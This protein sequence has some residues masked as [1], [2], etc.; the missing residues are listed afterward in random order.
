MALN[1]NEIRETLQINRS[2]MT[3]NRMLTNELIIDDFMVGL[4]YNKKRDTSVKRCYNGE[5]D[6]EVSS[7]TGFRIAVKVFA[8]GET[9]IQEELDKAMAYAGEKRFSI[10][11]VT[12][13]EALTVCRYIKDKGVYA[14]VCDINFEDELD[15]IGESVLSAISK[16][17]FD[18]QLIDKYVKQPTMTDDEM[19]ELIIS[20]KE[21]IASVV[22]A[23]S[24]SNNEDG[25]KQCLKVLDTILNRKDSVVESNINNRASSEEIAKAKQETEMLRAELNAAR[26]ELIEAKEKIT[27]IQESGGAMIDAD[28]KSIEEMKAEIDRLTA[29]VLADDTEKDIQIQELE[30]EVDRLKKK[31][32][33]SSQFT[34]GDTKVDNEIASYRDQIN[35]LTIKLSNE[36]ETVKQ[37]K[38]DLKKANDE[39]NNMTGV[40]RK[41][42]H[43]LLM[44]IEDNPDLDRHYVGVVNT[45]LLQYDEIHTFV[46]RSLQMLYELKRLEASQ[47]IFN[48]DIFKLIQPAIRNDLIMNNKAYDVSFEDRHE[49]D[50]LN[51]LRILFSHFNDVIFECKKIG[52]LRVDPFAAYEEAEYT[53]VN[54]ESDS[55]FTEGYIE[56]EVA[57]EYSEDNYT[58]DTNEYTADNTDYSVDEDSVDE[59]SVG[60]NSVGEEVIDFS[61]NNT[62][63]SLEKSEE[64][65][66]ESEEDLFA[67][68]KDS[69]FDELAIEDDT[70]DS[71]E[72][73][74]ELAIEDDTQEFR[75]FEDGFT[76]NDESQDTW[77]TDGSL[78]DFG[79]DDNFDPTSMEPQLIVAQ[80]LQIDN[81]I[82]MEDV[83]LELQNVKYIGTN[84]I[85]FNIN[86]DADE[87]SNEQLLC[88]CVDAVMAIEAYNGNS[89]IVNLLKQTDFSQINNFLQLYTDEFRGYPRINGTK[90]VVTNIDTIQQV[91]AV[92]YDICNY[93][94]ID[95]SELFIY[96]TATTD[97]DYII[98]NYGYEEDAVQ[99]R[100]YSSHDTYS[101]AKS[102]AIIQGDLFSNIVV[103]KGSLK[104]HKEIIVEAVAVKTKYLAK[105][106]NTDED[107]KEVVEQ[108]LTES[109]RFGRVDFN[110]IGNVIGETHKILS[111]N[112]YDIGNNYVELNV[113]GNYYYLAKVEKWQVLHSLIKLHTA[114]FNDTAIA[115]KTV[116]STDAI[117][118]Y[119]T[120]FETSEP[121]LSLA[122]KSF[123][124]YVALKVKR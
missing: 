92:L 71:E 64:T 5:V 45:E 110:A 114:I 26:E 6:W 48:G 68:G 60:E 79:E 19:T 105:V 107:Y 15:E 38:E 47:Y 34:T 42:A 2:D 23:K 11:I 124:D 32:I 7:P 22:I 106:L 77:E 10:F 8:I 75:G 109:A 55:E 12:N 95:M 25:K 122:V 119:G 104:A 70:D 39:I 46:G 40:E 90:Y 117:N 112:T 72:F 69:N 74:D 30:A 100:D 41:K 67:G 81:L 97:S 76:D 24:S 51:K 3:N 59:D 20:C 116:I 37:L 17:T 108:M 83:N 50:V 28:G 98:E 123:S 29:A 80:L 16:D 33:S 121:S 111:D 31:L 14:E 66:S 94:N 120:E 61:S 43:E 4:G 82:W 84:S 49:D 96:M 102:V 57:E 44:V 87:V 36:Q 56:D 18:L 63:I 113:A 99:L 103:T 58:E 65:Y 35:E 89:G 93:M 53:D 118:F 86:K 62:A 101:D 1:I 91:A 54:G 78:G 21:D 73:S 9:L 88:K 115:V 13:G 85:T 52:T 27:D